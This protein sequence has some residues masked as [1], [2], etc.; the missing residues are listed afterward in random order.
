M[1]DGINKAEFATWVQTIKNAARLCNLDALS[2]ALS[3][4]QGAPSTSANYL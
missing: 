1:F 4:L 2:I 3:K